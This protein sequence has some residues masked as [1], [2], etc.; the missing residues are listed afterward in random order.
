M[1]TDAD[2]QARVR[3]PTVE[4]PPSHTATL[5][6]EWCSVIEVFSATICLL[7][8]AVVE[9]AAYRLAFAAVVSAAPGSRPVEESIT[10]REPVLRATTSWR[11]ILWLERS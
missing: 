11:S 4:A 3:D 8:T 6:D 7:L 1:R 10:G 9:V 2:H 5:T